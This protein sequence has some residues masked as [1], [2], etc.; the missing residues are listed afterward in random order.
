MLFIS[1]KNKLYNIKKYFIVCIICTNKILVNFSLFS[2]CNLFFYFIINY[3]KTFFFITCCLPY[4]RQQ[5]LLKE[6]FIFII[7][8]NVIN[9]CKKIKIFNN[10][11]AYFTFTHIIQKKLRI[12]MKNNYK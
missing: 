4:N 2:T 1:F 6:N 5:D 10:I 3:Y 7:E 9:I 12:Y 11:N 8:I